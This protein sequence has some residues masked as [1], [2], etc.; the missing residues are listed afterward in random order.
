M[1][2]CSD[3]RYQDVNV[4]RYLMSTDSSSA[5]FTTHI[6]ACECERVPDAVAELCGVIPTHP[7][8]TWCPIRIKLLV[9]EEHSLSIS[10]FGVCLNTVHHEGKELGQ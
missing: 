4:Y 9:A 3:S 10:F 1:S 8:L 7:C 6:T 2:R 5:G